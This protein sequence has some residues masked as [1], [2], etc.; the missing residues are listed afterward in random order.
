MGRVNVSEREKFLEELIQ[1]LL[2]VLEQVRNERL[3]YPSPLYQAVD[4]AIRRA[5]ALL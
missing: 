3:C 2:K 4:A 1:D 5:R